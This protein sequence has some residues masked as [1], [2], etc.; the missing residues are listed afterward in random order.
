[1]CKT[2]QALSLDDEAI[3]RDEKVLLLGEQDI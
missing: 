1:M 2:D 3:H